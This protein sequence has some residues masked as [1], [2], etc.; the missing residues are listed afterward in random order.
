MSTNR[1]LLAQNQPTGNPLRSA[2]DLATEESRIAERYNRLEL[3]AGRL[4]ELSRSTQ[5]RRARLLRELVSKSRE[6]DIAG[7][8]DLIVKALEDDRLASA[9]ENQG[10]LRAELQKL[11]EL[12]LQEGRDRQIES[13]RKRI[14]KY[15]VELK[16][17]IRLQRGIKARTD[18]GDGAGELGKDQQRV[19]KA[20]G[21]LRDQI[22]EAEGKSKPASGETA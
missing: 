12:L 10:Q 15:L 4:A 8:F 14:G 3:L 21:K 22:D 20:T 6:Q 5:P 7:R 1:K 19:A 16:K 2:P 9:S 13:E 18:G 11:L 17:L